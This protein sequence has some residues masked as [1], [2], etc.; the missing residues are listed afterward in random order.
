MNREEIKQYFK[1][2]CTRY[3][4]EQSGYNLYKIDE[5]I[6]ATEKLVESLSAEPKEKNKKEGT[7]KYSGQWPE[8]GDNCNE[9]MTCCET[10][11]TD[12][13]N[14]RKDFNSKGK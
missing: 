14:H 4:F 1:D 3:G 7:F 5:V 12:W 11:Y 9:L 10:C 13:L 8:H 6:N 2:T